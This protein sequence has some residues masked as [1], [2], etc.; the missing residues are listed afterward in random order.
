MYQN[1]INR[2]ERDCDLVYW[3]NHPD[4][5][6]L[7]TPFACSF[8]EPPDYIHYPGLS[9]SAPNSIETYHCPLLDED[10][11]KARAVL[12]EPED[13]DVTVDLEQEI[14]NDIFNDD[15]ECLTREEKEEQSRRDAEWSLMLLAQEL[16]EQGVPREEI[17]SYIYQSQLLASSPS[18]PALHSPYHSPRALGPVDDQLDLDRIAKLT[19]DGIATRPLPPAYGPN[20]SPEPSTSQA[21]SPILAVRRASIS[22]VSSD[23]STRSG[24]SAAPSGTY[25][26]EEEEELIAKMQKVMDDFYE[27]NKAAIL[28]D[29]DQQERR[30]KRRVDR[31]ARKESWPNWRYHF[32]MT[33]NDNNVQLT[34][35]PE[36]N[37]I[38]GSV[39]TQLP[40]LSRTPI[41]D[42][43]MWELEGGGHGSAVR[44]RTS[45]KLTRRDLTD[46]SP[47][48]SYFPGPRHQG[49]R[50]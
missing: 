23:A 29:V 49:P 26:N 7:P 12:V 32:G 10:K 20:Y 28:S 11:G 39:H 22:S 8:P 47:T 48:S 37:W 16:S 31:A 40:T 45:K 34:H 1:S 33:G 4:E 27:A 35:G 25:T 19:V 15:E 18:I 6:D 30:R 17:E 13:D 44:E 9:K 2:I 36:G 41:P 14:F 24:S 5:D 42:N 46:Q 38:Q 43:D 50:Q 3:L 21:G